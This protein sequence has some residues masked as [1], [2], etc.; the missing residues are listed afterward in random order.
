MS[1]TVEKPLI[2]PEILEQISAETLEE[3]Q[4]IVHCLFPAT[5]FTGNLV[6][7]WQSTVL[8][9]KVSGHQSELV[10]AENI[11]VFPFWTEVPA[12]T[13]YWFTLVFTGL[14]KSCKSFD[15]IEIIHQSGGFH[16]KNIQRNSTDVYRVKIS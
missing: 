15:L 6:R 3:K 14:P 10:H 8:H 7:I 2:D 9:D 4:V 13:D 1:E 16:V 5:P 11:T 12:N